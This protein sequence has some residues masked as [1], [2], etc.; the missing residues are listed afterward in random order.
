MLLLISPAKNLNFESDIPTVKTSQPKLLDA[1]EVLVDQLRE[2]APHELSGLMGISDKL[3]Q[4]NYDRYQQ[5][6][7][8][9]KKSNARAA[10]L[11]FNGDVYQGLAAET[12]NADD[13]A[14]A[15]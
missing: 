2:M 6:L 5:W 3:G 8:P 9:F 7:R 4:L 14:F 11:A 12:F 15:Q 1:A 13:F 10:V